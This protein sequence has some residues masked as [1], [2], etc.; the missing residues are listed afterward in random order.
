VIAVLAA[1]VAIRPEPRDARMLVATTSGIVSVTPQGIR[2]PLLDDAQDA[3]YSPDGTFIAFARAGDLWLAN[4]DGTGKRRLA[5]TPNVAEWSPAW[6]ANG[7]LLVYTAR[8]GDKRQIRLFHLPTGPSSRI[9]GSD[10]EEWSPTLSRT[11][12]LAFVSSRSG[13]PAVYVANPDGTDARAFDAT[14]P[15]VP[16]TDIRDL[17]WSPDGRRLAYTTEA[18]DGTTSL[19]V[20][21]GTTETDL[22]VA[23]AK[24]E[25]PIWSP[26]GT[27]IA[28]DD[29]SDGLRSVAADGTD[30]RELGEGEPLDW[31]IV[32]VGKP[33]YPNLVQRRPSGLVVTGSARGHWLLGFTSMVDNRGPGILWI[34]GT[35]PIGSPVMFVRQLLELAGGGT[36]VLPESGELHYT[37]APPH[38]HWHFL[39]FD[40]YELRTVGTGGDPLGTLLVRDHKS[41]FCIADHYGIA[42]GVPHGV[43]RFLGSCAQ[44]DPKARSVEEG[45]S[46]GYTD[47]YPAYFHGQSLD[48]TKVPAG[49]YVLVHRANPDFHLRELRYDDDTSSLL[50]RIAWPGGHRAPPAISCGPARC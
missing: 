5:A 16:P 9:A 17:A 39:G 14:V 46:V 21:D 36:R 32:P 40:H 34:R 41:G 47:R 28:Y 38:Y 45:S 48:I 4:G 30:P 2:A 3:A 8:V 1:T 7:Q 22:S 27:R 31:R 24:D 26:S 33:K 25:H 20:D 49:R 43:P 10:T 50:V 29:G 18:A 6:S 23:P 13:T 19:V 37:V 42:I 44:F 11:G 12:R 35:R 15:D